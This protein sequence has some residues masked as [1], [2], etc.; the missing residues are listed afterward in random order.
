[1]RVIAQRP[2]KEY[3]TRHRDAE[4]PLR[5]WFVEAKAASWATP[6]DVKA[7]FGSASILKDSRVV[8]NIGGNKHRLVV[9]INYAHGIVF[10][11]FIGT[12]AE[13]DDIDAENVSP[14]W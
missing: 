5:A 10:V 13:Y 3:W 1:M 6:Q 8:F 14:T 2:L 4:E 9:H 12:H 11:K 7:K